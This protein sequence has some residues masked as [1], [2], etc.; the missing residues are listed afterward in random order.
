MKTLFVHIMK[1]KQKN[2]RY[3]EYWKIKAAFRW[4]RVGLWFALRA[5]LSLCP[6]H[7]TC[8]G[9]GQDIMYHLTQPLKPPQGQTHSTGPLLAFPDGSPWMLWAC[10]A[11]SLDW[12]FV[13]KGEQL[14]HNCKFCAH[15][16]ITAEV[17]GP[18]VAHMLNSSSSSCILSSWITRALFDS[19]TV[20]KPSSPML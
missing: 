11:Y 1:K 9:H 12:R 5:H 6:S 13:V 16:K 3:S 7:D 14:T 4:Q 19:I 15:E 17:F 2:T 20:S 10:S 18:T 8:N